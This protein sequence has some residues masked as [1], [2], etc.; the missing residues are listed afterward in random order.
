MYTLFGVLFTGAGLS[1]P[2]GGINWRNVLREKAASIDIDV[3]RKNNLISVA[4]Y[5]Y[6]E[7]GMRQTITQLLK[8]EI[9]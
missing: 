4:Q 2:S 7:S 8:N 9:S 5:I 6:N 3:N 1:I